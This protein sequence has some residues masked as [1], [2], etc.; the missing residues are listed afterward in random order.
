[1]VVV[2]GGGGVHV[3]FVVCV[4]LCLFVCMSARV[5]V[6]VFFFWGDG[7]LSGW[8]LVCVYVS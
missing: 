8:V 4:I 5:C 6:C 1:M 7:Y 2:G 3:V